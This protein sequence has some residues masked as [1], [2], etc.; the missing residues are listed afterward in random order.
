MIYP[1]SPIGGWILCKMDMKTVKINTNLIFG[2]IAI[3]VSIV[4][5]LLI[6]S[7]VPPSLV[8]T[9]FINGSFMPKL[10]SGI[11]FICGLISIL[12]GFFSKNKDKKE[13]CLKLESKNMLYL[14]MIGVFVILATKVSFLMAS[15]LFGVSSLYFM[16][17][18][19]IKKY[20]IVAL[21]AVAVCLIFKYGLK[22]KFGGLW[23]I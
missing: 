21:V 15:V 13:I 10:M 6:P 14:L 22:V 23:G 12:K 16:H 3:V 2:I 5:W 4:L 18:K 1:S 7:Q 9:E 11:M 19:N 17:C 8:A 20:I